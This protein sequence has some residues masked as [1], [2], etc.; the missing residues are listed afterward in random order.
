M[1]KILKI[2]LNMIFF[3]KKNLVFEKQLIM[4]LYLGMGKQIPL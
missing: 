3:I 4:S 2:S 1:E